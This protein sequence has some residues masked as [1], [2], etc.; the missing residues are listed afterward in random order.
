L[1]ATGKGNWAKHWAAGGPIYPDLDL[2]GQARGGQLYDSIG[3]L[4]AASQAVF[5]Y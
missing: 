4:I 1:A 2:I 3:G 5:K